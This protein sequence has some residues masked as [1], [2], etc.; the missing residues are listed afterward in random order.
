MGGAGGQRMGGAGGQD[1]G[2]DGRGKGRGVGRGT[3]VRL[4]VQEVQERA[5][6]QAAWQNF[7]T[8]MA[9]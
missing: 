7:K 2:R 9:G 8:K 4:E 1:Q 6:K 3:R 5:G